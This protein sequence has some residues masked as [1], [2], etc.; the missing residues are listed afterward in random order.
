MSDYLRKR[1]EELIWESEVGG[2]VNLLPES[3]GRQMVENLVETLL[4]EVGDEET[5]WEK[6][7]E[8]GE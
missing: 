8:V 3:L 5:D 1:F 6:L 2:A 4:V 7:E